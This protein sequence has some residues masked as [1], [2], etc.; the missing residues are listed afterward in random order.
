LGGNFGQIYRWLLAHELAHQYFGSLVGLPRNEIGWAPIGL[1]LVMDRHYCESIELDY[2]QNRKT[3][4]WFYEEAERRGFNTSLSQ[5]VEELMSAPAPWSTGWTM[6]LAHGKAL[7]V[8]SKFEEALGKSE[9]KALIHDIV[10]DKSGALLG[11]A[12]LIAYVEKRLGRPLDQPLKDWIN[13]SPIK[14]NP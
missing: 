8:C 1:G 14:N 9:M 7:L 10:R 3:M 11:G 5:P 2:N 4:V 12:D 13:G 6:S